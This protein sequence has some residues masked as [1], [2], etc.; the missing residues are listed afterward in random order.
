MILDKN[1]LS[2]VAEGEAAVEPILRK[3]T[4]VAIPVIVLGEYRYGIAQS[5][6]LNCYKQWL[7]ESFA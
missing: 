5:R 4:Q 2:A 6:E 1:G 3:A 7:S